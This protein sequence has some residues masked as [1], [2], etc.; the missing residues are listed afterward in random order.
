MEAD[1]RHVDI[2]VEIAA[3]KTVRVFTDGPDGWWEGGDEATKSPAF[4]RG[5]IAD[6]RLVHAVFPNQIRRDFRG[7]SDFQEAAEA[8]AEIPFL[9]IQAQR[10]GMEFESGFRLALR[11]G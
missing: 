10:R 9:L 11:S 5:G 4:F 7:S 1:H 3:K 6:L 2:V 8:E